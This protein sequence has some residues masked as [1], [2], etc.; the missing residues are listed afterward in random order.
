MNN[1]TLQIEKLGT[2]K[3][4]HYH[5][6]LLASK[7]NI[8]NFD[9]N[10]DGFNFVIVEK[11]GVQRFQY[12]VQ[13]ITC[14]EGATVTSFATCEDLQNFLESWGYTPYLGLGGGGATN[15]GY[16]PSPTNGIVTSSTGTSATIPLADGT[17]AGLFSSDEKD[18]L[19]NQSGTNT[20]DETAASIAIINH[21]T[22]EKTTLVDGDEMSG[23]NSATGFSL[24]RFTCLNL[25]NY[26]K[27]KFDSIYTT[28]SWVTAQGFITN[29]ISSLGYT[30]ENVSN[31][32]IANGYVPLNS[33]T[34]INTIYLPDSILGQ[35]LYG[36]VVNATTVVATL[37][38]NA[39][40]KLGTSSST[41]TLTNDTTAITGYIANEGL[42]YICSTAGTFAGI[43]F[44]VGDWLLSVG[45]SWAKI[46]NTDAISSF[47]T[48]TGAIVLTLAD[49][50]TALAFTPANKAGD[51]FTGAVTVP[52]IIVSSETASSIASFDGS[53]NIKSL[54]TATYP[55]LAELIFLKGVTGAIQT[56]I[57]AKLNVASPSFTGTMS[58]NGGT[59]TTSGVG[60]IDLFQTWNNS[61]AIITGFKMNI[62]DT[63]SSA[64][65]LLMDLQI[66]GVSKFSV[67]KSGNI[68][69]TGVI[70]QNIYQAAGGSSGVTLRFN[71][72]TTTFGLK[73]ENAANLNYI[74]HITGNFN[75]LQL[76]DTS[77]TP[78]SGNAT[79]SYINLSNTINQTGGANGTIRGFF[80]NPTITSLI[81]E[82]R[83]LDIQ[84]G[85]LVFSST[86]TAPGTTGT[87]TINKISGKVNA[88][89]GATSL[90][91]TNSLVTTSSI[92]MCQLGTND[93]T[94][95]ITA[96]VEA[97][98]SFT[99]HLI[100]PAAETVIKFFIIN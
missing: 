50:T 79:F 52:S 49:V 53:K 7:F 83:A 70:K 9:V 68:T 46:D 35:L 14:K 58:G 25:Y 69:F 10:Y 90:V 16:T 100:A 19:N 96:V 64:S 93:S 81:G 62:T 72:N 41:I 37:T 91:V 98:G 47:N 94:A 4:W 38:T 78:A 87:Q 42:Y 45:S 31:K 40:S 77:F 5:N 59:R 33:S 89:A 54:S 18:N 27:G 57:D 86:I 21:G 30:P 67:D 71:G 84:Q 74:E 28:Q 97:T 24:I 85:K 29:V 23:Q 22:T 51:T 99:I 39:K 17:N 12:S 55:S 61:L 92:V 43:S 80:F 36:G 13:N 32:G 63:A 26:I 11:N 56:Q 66:G 2:A 20:G 3:F 15:L 73:V 48:R 75:Y 65:S 95:R 82:L 8:S 88:A 34:K 44:D 76:T 6:G 1:D 60:L